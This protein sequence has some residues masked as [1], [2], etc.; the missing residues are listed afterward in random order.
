[1]G[2]LLKTV[3]AMILVV[4]YPKFTFQMKKTLRIPREF[5]MRSCLEEKL[6]LTVC[7]VRFPHL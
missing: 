4:A 1:M 7:L 5:Q 2:L 6:V 3:I